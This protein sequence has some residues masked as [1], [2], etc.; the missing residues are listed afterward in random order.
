MTARPATALASLRSLL[1]VP[2]NREAMLQKAAKAR[3]DVFVPDLEDSVPSDE[4]ENAREGVARSLDLLA[5]T[6]RPVVPRLNGIDTVWLED[7]AMALVGP[8]VAGVSVG[9]IRTPDDIR[10]I[11]DLL[12]RAEARR[13]VPVGATRLIPWIE[14]APA[15]LD[16]L[17]ISTA[18]PRIVAIAFGAEDLTLDMG[19]QRSSDDS[20]VSVA[21]S[22]TCLAAA[23]A[24]VPALDT[25]FFAFRDDAAL[26]HNA[27][28]S[29]RLGFRGKFAIHPDQLATIERV[30]SP[31]KEEL[32]EAR[33]VI[34]A[35]EAAAKQGRGSTSLDGRVV[36][37]PVVERAR[38][39]LHAARTVRGDAGRED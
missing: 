36:D 8:A 26:A 2:G 17:R 15:V 39:L 3:P 18:S 1:F 35:F 5:A 6:G 14:T 31:S 29:K 4:K 20:E 37:V 32:A 34:E 21:R 16:C 9:K 7:D 24:R 38:A 12:A 23:A 22:L 28:A 11:D 19:I 13:G 33:R 27:E 25:P 10:R 30:F